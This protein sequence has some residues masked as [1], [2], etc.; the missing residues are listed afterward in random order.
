MSGPWLLVRAAWGW[1]A[2]FLL[3]TLSTEI[4]IE[5]PP[6]APSQISYSRIDSSGDGAAVY[7]LPSIART[8]TGVLAACYDARRVNASDLG[9]PN[10]IDVVCR[11][12]SDA[13]IT[14]SD[15]LIVAR[16]SSGETPT[17]SYNVGDPN[18]TYDRVRGRL[19][20]H[21]LAAPPG[22]GLSNSSTSAIPGDWSTVHPLARY[23]DDDGATWSGIVD[24]TVALKTSGM[25]GIF[26][27][28][29][30]G[31][32][33]QNGTLLVPYVFLVGGV[34]R[35][36]YAY[37]LDGQTWQ[38]GAW[39]GTGVGEHHAVQLADGSLFDSARSADS[40]VLYR[41][42]STA[43]GVLGP[44]SSATAHTG[45][46]DPLC[47]GD[48]LRA[49]T[50]TSSRAS[51]LLSSNPDSQTVR[52]N[53]V[54]RQSRD[55]GVMWPYALTIEPGLGGYSALIDLGETRYGV[56]YEHAYPD[57]LVFA[58]FALDQFPG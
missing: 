45:L 40:S 58:T 7:R 14:W 24:L 36:A 2:A 8:T 13:G 21:Y 39:M 52:K 53:L 19:W 50:D 27:S 57:S 42:L 49:D 55:N 4:Q 16:H 29:G 5:T 46:P 44:W 26:A 3:V 33:L 34:T 20:L 6:A 12:S 48:V 30:R 23:S 17:T 47:N 38:M 37:S 35:A 22:I 41:R 54:I 51:W 31:V 1:C 56:F 11:R 32:Q 9:Q 18:L 10:I 15:R 25:T 28:G 43:P